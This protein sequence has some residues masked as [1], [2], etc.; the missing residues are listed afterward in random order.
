MKKEILFTL[1]ISLALVGCQPASKSSSGSSASLGTTKIEIFSSNDLH[2]Q[3][4]KQP[5]RCGILEYAQFF[6]ERGKKAN[7]LLIDQ[8]DSW[9]GSIYSNHNHGAMVSEIMSYIGVDAR[10]V[11]NHDF[12]W[13]TEYLISNTALQPY[14]K[15]YNLAGNVYSFNFNTKEV[16]DEQLSS[17]GDKHAIFTLENGLK[18]GVL[19]GIG[20]NQIT[21]ICSLYTQDLTFTD[22]I[23]YIK[24][25]SQILKDEGCDVI[26]AAMHT[27]QEEL[28]GYDLSD[29]VDWVFC[30]HTHREE[31]T[32]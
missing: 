29:Y 6:M 15:V 11:G 2:G 20:K 16:G 18:V 7:T 26:I 17:M 25:E 1:L 31:R 10:T 28:L 23:E 14:N 30:G 22:H 4:E 13:G 9:Q 24:S 21:S 3:I 27:G 12:D 32:T 19:G 8:G 5:G